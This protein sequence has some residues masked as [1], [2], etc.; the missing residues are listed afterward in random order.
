MQPRER[1]P[2]LVA[3]ATIWATVPTDHSD[4]EI[5]GGDSSRFAALR[6]PL[7]GVVNARWTFWR[8]QDAALDRTNIGGRKVQELCDRRGMAQGLKYLRCEYETTRRYVEKNWMVL[9]R[10]GAL[11]SI[12][13]WVEAADRHVWKGAGGLT[14]RN[15]LGAFPDQAR[16][17]GSSTAVPMSARTLADEI[18]TSLSTASRS[19]NRSMEGNGNRPGS[20]GFSPC[21]DPYPPPESGVVIDQRGAK[22]DRRSG[23]SHDAR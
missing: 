1:V 18:G 12:T 14:D 6:S 9:G 10:N 15:E 21:F 16:R 4:S 11:L 3:L 5:R 7:V 2:H 13:E 20:R 17:T 22:R 19:V 8:I 23:S